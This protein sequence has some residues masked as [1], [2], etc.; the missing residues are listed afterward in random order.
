MT[1]RLPPSAPGNPGQQAPRRLRWIGALAGLLLAAGLAGS[2]AMW[3]FRTVAPPVAQSSGDDPSSDADS[4][5]LSASFAVEPHDNFA[6]SQACRNCHEEEYKAWHASYHRTMTQFATPAAVA[7]PLD[8]TKLES[9]GRTYQFERRGEQ[10]FVTMAEPEWEM[11]RQQSGQELELIADPP[12]TTREIV[13]L[14]GS[15]QM[16]TYW[17]RAEDGFRQVPWYWHIAERAW[18]PAEDSFL[19]PPS[20]QRA[21]TRWND[22][23]IKCHTTG[24]I[25]GLQP[26]TGFDTRVADLGI[27]CEACHGHG[28]RHIALQEQRASADPREIAGAK[29]RAPDDKICNPATLPHSLSSQ[30]CGQCHSSARIRD[31]AGWSAEGAKFQPGD[32][33]TEHFYVVQF[34]KQVPRDADYLRN[35]YWADGTCRTAGDEYQGLLESACHLR[36]ELSCLSCHSLH[37]YADRSDQLARGME[38]NGACLECH[39]EYESRLTEHTHH[40]AGSSGSLCYNCHMPHISYGLLKGIRSHRI[41]SPSAAVTAKT[42]RP[43]ACNLCHLDQTLGWTA[44]HLSQWY[45]QPPVELA[46]DD[47]TIAASVRWLLS[48]DATQRAIAAW[49]M[50]WPEAQAA[51]GKDWQAAMLAYSLDDPYSAIRYVGQRSL[52]SARGFEQFEYDFVGSPAKRKAA[53]QEALARWRQSSD[54]LPPRPAVLLGSGGQLLESEVQRLRQERDDRPITIHE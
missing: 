49:H 38:G 12:L 27:A 35:D 6:G 24:E 48:G 5:E 13:L 9:R 53:V 46:N 50:G 29:Q 31:L 1:N 26:T 40:G 7:A 51:S 41:D 33:L 39:A 10:F 45:N 21:F 14:T 15:H 42:E 20:N 3:A 17:I 43:N 4:R 19:Q 47:R 25:P 36:G 16:Q 11:E 34:G 2:W 18:I 37:Q 44:D 54:S 32:K 22:V 28:R 23:C 8:G 52:K 30:V